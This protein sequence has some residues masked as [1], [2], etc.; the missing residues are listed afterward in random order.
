[1]AT[2][3]SRVSYDGWV[4]PAS[5]GDPW[6]DIVPGVLTFRGSPTRRWHGTG[7]VPTDPAVAWR[8]PTEGQMCSMSSVAGVEQ[9]W[10]GMGWTGQPAVFERQGRTWVVFGAFDA[11][12]HFLD[13]GTGE[14]IIPDFATADIIKGSVTVDPDGYPL[15]Y[16]GSRDDRLRILAIDRARPTEL[17][18]LDADDTGPRMWNND[19]D[20]SPLVLDDHL[21]EGGENSR[22][23]VVR[24]NRSYDDDGHV[25][26]DP[27]LVW[28]VAGWDDDLLAEVDSNVSIENS[29]LIVGNTL[30][31]ANSGGLVQ[32]WDIAGLA[33]GVEPTR[34]F[35]FW[36]GDDVDATLVPDDDGMLYVGVEYERE[37]VRSLEL[38]QILKLDPSR[39]DDP[40]VWAVEAHTKVGT[41]VWATPAIYGDLV[42]VPTADG[43]VLGISRADG[44]VRWRLEIPGPVW[45]SPTIVD[46]VMVIGDCNGTVRAFDLSEAGSVPTQIWEVPTGVCVESSAAVWDGTIYV[47]S[48][49]GHL[50]ALRDPS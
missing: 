39:P 49:D 2:P 41:G 15:V 33:D 25:A 18:G 50:Y 44:E 5:M 8:F 48:R 28:D 22:F 10:C 21:F 34:V 12:V 20:A 38:G 40:L 45:S 30:Y 9:E 11:R 13:G 7:P 27:E 4:D 43:E 14:K 47:G 37:T 24:L 23:H 32:G 31:F 6:G 35:R 3:V 29:P 42:V 16:V 46:D 17:W 19:W 26:V 1:M 36:V